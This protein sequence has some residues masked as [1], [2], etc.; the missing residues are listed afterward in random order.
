MVFVYGEFFCVESVLVWRACSH[1]VLEGEL[2]LE[3]LGVVK[4]DLFAQIH[5]EGVLLLSLGGVVLLAMARQL[6]NLQAIVRVLGH[7]S[8]FLESLDLA[9]AH[10]EPIC[11]HTGRCTRCCCLHFLFTNFKL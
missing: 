10:L 4:F 9:G 2:D 5:E 3:D 1:G 8:L 11:R 7:L 6:V